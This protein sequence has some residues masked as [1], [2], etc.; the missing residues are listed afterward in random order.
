VPCPRSLPRRPPGRPPCRGTL[1]PGNGS[2]PCS[3]RARPWVRSRPEMALGQL[4]TR[5]STPD[6]IAHAHAAAVPSLKSFSWACHDNSVWIPIPALVAPAPIR[7]ARHAPT[8]PASSP[9]PLILPAVVPRVSRRPPRHRRPPDRARGAHRTH[10]HQVRTGPHCGRMPSPRRN[11]PRAYVLVTTA[12]DVG[13][14][15][16]DG[17]GDERV[18]G[19]V[20]R[21]MG[22][23]CCSGRRSAMGRR[24]S[25]SSTCSS[26]R[27]GP[28]RSHQGQSRSV[29]DGDH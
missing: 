27:P 29:D 25:C 26:R 4:V 5:R 8:A 2:L 20:T 23:W 11:G 3:G 12:Q 28:P 16:V 17:K 21:L 22:V 14:C 1:R 9:S 7:W 15:P 10:R 6:V 13:A 19:I 18:W 24:R